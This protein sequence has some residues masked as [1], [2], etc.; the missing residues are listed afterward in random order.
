MKNSNNSFFGLIMFT[1]FL[2]FFAFLLGFHKSINS[3]PMVVYS[4]YLDGSAI[5]TLASRD[6]FEDFINDK[7]EE[8]K[9]KYNVD[10]V[11]TPKGVEIKKN[12]TYKSSVNSNQDV[13]NKI[14]S[15]K[16]FTVKGYEITIVGEDT[17]DDV[18]TQNVTKLYVLSKDV[19]D[20]AVVDT[21]KAFVDE[22]AYEKFVSGTQEEIKDLGSM[23]ENIDLGETITYKE[24]YIPTDE[25]IFVDA[26]EL[27]K[28]LL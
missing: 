23:I 14:I 4:V 3:E 10:T 25:N 1:I 16:K 12:I 19:F 15:N 6:S 17:Q 26:Q 24:T 20:E 7:E 11:Y 22:E 13:Y 2:C 9:E 8:L 5:G 27:S 21:I 18:T 28:Y